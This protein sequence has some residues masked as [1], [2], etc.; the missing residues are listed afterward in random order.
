MSRMNNVLT[1]MFVNICRF[2]PCLQLDIIL[3]IL[4]NTSRVCLR[5]RNISKYILY[6]TLYTCTIVTRA[7]LLFSCI[8]IHSQSIVKTMYNKASVMQSQHDRKRKWIKRDDL[9]GNRTTNHKKNN[10]NTV[11][12][13]VFDIW[14]EAYQE[15][16][17]VINA[18]YDVQ[19]GRYILV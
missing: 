18:S 5:T 8:L 2:S 7:Q 17:D 16:R 15:L 12:M 11:F 6:H 13:S 14:Y 19:N 3:L 4:L 9:L 1:Y 10:S